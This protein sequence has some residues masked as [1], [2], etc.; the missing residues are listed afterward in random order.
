MK[1]SI[2]TIRITAFTTKGLAHAAQIDRTSIYRAIY[3]GQL[4][5]IN[6]KHHPLRISYK[7]A[8]NWILTR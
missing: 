5:P 7:E 2:P 8:Y 3:K 1:T 4:K 6:K